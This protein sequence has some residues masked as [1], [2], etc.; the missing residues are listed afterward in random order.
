MTENTIDTEKQLIIINGGEPEKDCPVTWE[1][2]N[3]ILAKINKDSST[4][5]WKF[6]CG[7]KLDYDGSLVGVQSRFYP[8]KSHYG[9]NWDGE[10]HV[11]ILGK[12]V[13]T[14]EVT[15]NCLEDLVKQVEAIITNLSK[16]FKDTFNK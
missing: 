6:D 9:P 7:F 2:A 11:L 5:Q 3:T 15:A 16:L 13:K 12:E 4:I 8:P 14:Y 10:V 1:E